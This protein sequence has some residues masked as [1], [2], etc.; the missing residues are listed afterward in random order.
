MVEGRPH[1]LH[2][3]KT[4]VLYHI[5]LEWLWLH[6]YHLIPS[7]YHQC[8]KGRLNGKTIRIATNPSPFE[9]AEAHLVKTMFY[10]EWAP[11]REIYVSRLSSTFVPRWDDIQNDLELDLRE[12]LKRKRKRKEAPTTNQ[13]VC[14]ATSGSKH[15]TVE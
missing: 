7:T 11:L 5:L 4:E 2:V 14:R 9:Q 8:V 3:M 6:K 10:D 12:M 13:K 1:S 15:L